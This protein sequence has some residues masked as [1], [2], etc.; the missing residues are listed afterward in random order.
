MVTLYLSRYN[1]LYIISCSSHE[2]FAHSRTRHS[3]YTLYL[4]RSLDESQRRS[5]CRTWRQYGRWRRVRQQKISR[6]NPQKS[7]VCYCSYFPSLCYCTSLYLIIIR[8]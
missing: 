5:G 1:V 3:W 6:N 8:C 2:N 7:S 4:I